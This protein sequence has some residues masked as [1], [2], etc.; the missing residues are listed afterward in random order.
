MLY[1]KLS[2]TLMLDVHN[3]LMPSNI[4]DMFTLTQDIHNYNTRSSSSGNLYI[5]YSRLNLQKNTF[6]I[7][8]A[9]MWN[10]LPEDLRHL[11]EQEFKSKCISNSS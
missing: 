5:N 9:K 7:I 6:P 4:C 1:F 10:S 3:K 2:S 8:G 11:P